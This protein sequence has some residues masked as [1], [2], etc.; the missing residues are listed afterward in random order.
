MRRTG[1]DF[2]ATLTLCFTL[3]SSSL[4]YAELQDPTK[5][6]FY[7]SQTHSDYQQADFLKL[8]TIWVSNKIKRV[9]INGITAKQGD[10]ILSDVKIIKIYTNSVLIEQNGTRSTL[11]LLTRSYK[12]PANQK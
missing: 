6:V 12:T 11:S 5:P 10:I 8:S 4:C 1:L 7:S 2:K 3:L 9:T